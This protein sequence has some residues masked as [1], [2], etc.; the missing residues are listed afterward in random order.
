MN[1]EHVINDLD[2]TAYVVRNWY[3]QDTFKTLVELPW[4]RQSLK[5]YGKK[6]D[7]ARYSINCGEEYVFNAALE[8]SQVTYSWDGTGFDIVKALYKR[9]TKE[10]NFGINNCF[11]NYYPEGKD[12]IGY[13]HDK[14]LADMNF[15]CSVSFG[16]SRDF[17]LKSDHDGSVTKTKLHDGDLFVMYGETNNRYKHSIP[18]RAKADARI[19][20]TFRKIK[21]L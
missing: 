16:G 9:L 18:K 15:V 11:M 3:G 21:S 1:K 7:E 4:R 13:H 12:H 17:Y 10:L 20:L 14:Y 5:I 2:C 19:S 6:V 8:G